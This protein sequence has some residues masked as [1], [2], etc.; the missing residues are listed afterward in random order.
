MR[1]N[2][3]TMINKALGIV[4][5]PLVLI[6]T[7]QQQWMQCKIWMVVENKGRKGRIME[8]KRPQWRPGRVIKMGG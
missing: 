8:N 3:W 6:L 1:C 7:R 2:S 4:D 5:Y